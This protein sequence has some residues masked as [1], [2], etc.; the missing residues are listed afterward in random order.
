MLSGELPLTA[1]ERSLPVEVY[2]WPSRRS[3]TREPA[4]E[5]HTLG[6]QPLLS[7]ALTALCTAGAR[8]AEPGEFTLRAFLAGRLD[9]TQAEAVL[10]VI[11]ARGQ[12]D[13]ELAL[14]QL[15]GG[16]AKPLRALRERLFELLAHLEAGL[17]FVEEDIEFISRDQLAATIA[18]SQTVVEQLLDQ[19]QSRAETVDAARVVLIGWP[20]VGKS[21][22]FNALTGRAAIVAHEPGTTRDYLTGWMDAAGIRC[23][24]VD[25]AG[26]ETE[27]AGEE[28][29]EAAQRM[30][31]E[32]QARCE[33]QLLCLDASRGLNDWEL[34]QLS[35]TAKER[36][37]VLTK[38]DVPLRIDY[39]G[40]L[41]GHDCVRTSALSGEGLDDL[42]RAVAARVT[43]SSRSAVGVVMA[44]AVRSRESLHASQEALERAAM[45]NHSGNGEELI[46]AEIRA[47]LEEI[48]KVAGAIYTDDLLDR[49]FSRFC[50][51]K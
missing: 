8:V 7:A 23:E 5:I 41:S 37:V 2:L 35:E 39:R 28:L 14:S 11:D 31:A 20:N 25:T 42:R 48:G 46:A 44:T 24:L 3:Y 29:R 27:P 33:V 4:A 32:Q 9:L 38:C 17:D 36:L 50:I 13:F 1:L 21:S 26:V 30:T 6:S 12:E 47:A 10:G 18:Q 34:A 19:M 45:L 40:Q 16:L 43:Q 51:G 15:A 49:I 22:L